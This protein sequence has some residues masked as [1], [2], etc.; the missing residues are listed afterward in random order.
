MDNVENIDTN[1]YKVGFMFNF[2]GYQ[3]LFAIYAN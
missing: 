1:E 2:D 3:I